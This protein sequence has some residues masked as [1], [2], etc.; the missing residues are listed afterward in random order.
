MVWNV[1]FC[2]RSS[3]SCLLPATNES[4]MRRRSNDAARISKGIVRSPHVALSRSCTSLPSNRLNARK[5]LLRSQI[6]EDLDNDDVCHIGFESHL[7]TKLYRFVLI[8]FSTLTIEDQFGLSDAR[9]NGIRGIHVV[10]V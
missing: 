3:R 7:L 9:Y 6:I 10:L 2:Q 1:G 5:A 4:D 8:E